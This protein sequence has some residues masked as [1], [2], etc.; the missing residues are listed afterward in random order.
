VG[1]EV[2]IQA[3]AYVYRSDLSQTKITFPQN[4]QLVKISKIVIEPKE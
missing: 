2:G 3:E 1:E 4:I